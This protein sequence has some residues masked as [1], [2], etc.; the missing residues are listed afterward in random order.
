MKKN[1]N[2]YIAIF[3]FAFMAVIGSYNALM[4]S[5]D[6]LLSG[7]DS[8]KFKRL[9]E[10]YGVVKIGRSLAVATDW[11]KVSKIEQKM[12]P[13]GK[14]IE[15]SSTKPSQTL[16]NTTSA[17]IQDSLSL[18][19]VEVINPQKW[20]QGTKPSDFSGLIH[21]NNGIIESLNASL[22]E[23]MS[24]DISFSEMTGNTFEYDL[25]GEVYTGMMYQVDQNAYMI[26]MTNGPLEGTRLRFAGEATDSQTQ[27]F[28]AENH[29]IEMGAFSEES[30]TPALEMENESQIQT[31]DAQTFNFNQI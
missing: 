1:Q 26:T 25:N 5:S 23:G 20:Q 22:P 16:E 4:I 2:K 24:I 21:T 17:A 15:V 19:L 29:N 31:A 3:T 7:T 14:M 12:G 13:Q 27:N 10:D 9:D 8:K 28:L 6:S 11:R 30:E 18:K